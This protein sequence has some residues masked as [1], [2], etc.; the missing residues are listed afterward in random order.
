MYPQGSSRPFGLQDMAG[1]VWEW[2]ASWYSEKQGGRVL[3]GGSWYYNQGRARVSI[4]ASST[5]DY[6]DYNIGFRPVA[7]VDSGS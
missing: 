2:T 3:R 4:R 7:P 6:A 1:N 5:P